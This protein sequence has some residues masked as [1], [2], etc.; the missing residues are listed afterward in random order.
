MS[1]T[2]EIFLLLLN[3]YYHN[4]F[5]HWWIHIGSVFKFD[6][7]REH[8]YQYGYIFQ[9]LY[10]FIHSEKKFVV[11]GRCAKPKFYF[12]RGRKG[13]SVSDFSCWRF[14]SCFSDSLPH[15]MFW[16]AASFLPALSF[17][18]VLTCHSSTT[19]VRIV[20]SDNIMTSIILEYPW[21]PSAVLNFEWMFWRLNWWYNKVLNFIRF[22]FIH[23]VST[24]LFV[25]NWFIHIV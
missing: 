13:S 2:E 4:L 16:E 3:F 12:S 23:N 9:Q 11:Y 6:Y 7:F 17:D 14:A 8:F 18:F 24:N 10:I 1:H 25:N 19:A 22:L 5:I 20:Q 21:F 15:F